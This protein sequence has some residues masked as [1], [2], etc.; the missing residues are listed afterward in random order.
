LVDL[1]EDAG[2][3]TLVAVIAVVVGVVAA[4]GLRRRR[5]ADHA[6]SAAAVERARGPAA[7]DRPGPAAPDE[8]RSAD[9]PPEEH[10]GS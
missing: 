8:A 7:P 9:L 3:A 2:T 10:G 1:L 6:G 5:I 4:E